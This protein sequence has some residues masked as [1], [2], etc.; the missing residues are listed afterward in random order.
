MTFLDREPEPL[1]K[2]AQEFIAD[3]HEEAARAEELEKELKKR[4]LTIYKAS[5]FG[6]APTPIED[7]EFPAAGDFRAELEQIGSDL[8]DFEREIRDLD[9]GKEETQGL[10]DQLKERV[11]ALKD[12]QEEIEDYVKERREL[13]RTLADLDAPVS[14]KPAL[15]KSQQE[16]PKMVSA[17]QVICKTLDEYRKSSV[18]KNYME[19]R[20]F[21]GAAHDFK[22]EMDAA[23]AEGGAQILRAKPTITK[24]AASAEFLRSARGLVLYALKDHP[25]AKM[26]TRDE[27]MA[28]LE[29]DPQGRS[30]LMGFAEEM[31]QWR[32]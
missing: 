14:A 5:H 31:L 15:S 2:E 9:V 21:E 17:R 26:G 10:I 1:S 19:L 27:V 4:K 11:G 24:E 3:V 16:R 20:E 28:R 7:D 6:P 18:A 30:D 8:I 22:L 13:M 23:L 12:R 29:N 25:L 32:T